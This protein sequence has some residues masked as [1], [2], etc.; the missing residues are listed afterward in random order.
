MLY[1]K[2]SAVVFSMKKIAFE[3][4]IKWRIFFVKGLITLEKIMENTLKN[5][6]IRKV[7][8]FSLLALSALL[9]LGYLIQ[10]VMLYT[11]GGYTQESVAKALTQMLLPSV[12]WVAYLIATVVIYNIF[13]VEKEK[14][15]GVI[16][17]ATQLAKLSAKLPEEAWKPEREALKKKCLLLWSIASGLVL[18]SFIFPLCYLLNPAN[19]NRASTNTEMVDAAA[20]T[21]PFVAF[22]FAVVIIAWLYGQK[23]LKG[24][25][26]KAKALTVQA[27]KEG[28]LNKSAEVALKDSWL[29]NPKALWAV[30]GAIIVLSIVLIVFGIANGGFENVMAKAVALCMECVGLA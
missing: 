23:L 13:P 26:A 28:K 7:C 1:N 6:K 14:T 25:I 17:P 24:G 11:G 18:I 20:H 2:E 4:I 5:V 16:N 8:G 9:G 30:R 15:K 21:L 10:A 12:L 29:D 22:A 19:F 27:A 3:S